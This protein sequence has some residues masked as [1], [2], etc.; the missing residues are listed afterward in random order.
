MLFFIDRF[1]PSPFLDLFS[2]FP[3]SKLEETDII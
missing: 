1:L 3:Y 2:C